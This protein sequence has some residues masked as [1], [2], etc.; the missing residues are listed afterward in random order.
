MAGL[1]FLS[2]VPS[3]FCFH[4]VDVNAEHHKTWNKLILPFMKR[5]FTESNALHTH[6]TTFFVG[7]SHVNKEGGVF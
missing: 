2:V 4:K 3:R 1:K 6:P 7:N 5:Q